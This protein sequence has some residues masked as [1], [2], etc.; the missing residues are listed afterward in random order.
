MTMI[1]PVGHVSDFLLYAIKKESSVTKERNNITA[2][3]NL[4]MFSKIPLEKRPVIMS[5]F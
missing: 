2:Q 1:R 5:F 3:K 4:S